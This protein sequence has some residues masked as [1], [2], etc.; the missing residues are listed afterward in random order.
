MC[1][2]KLLL[3]QHP[4]HWDTEHFASL[5]LAQHISIYVPALPL[6]QDTGAETDEQK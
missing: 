5:S 2:H 1:S 3:L 4:S 6:S